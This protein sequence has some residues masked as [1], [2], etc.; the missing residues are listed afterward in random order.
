MTPED[1]L[2]DAL[3]ARARQFDADPGLR[4]GIES[5]ALA[6]QR[7]RRLQIAG[8]SALAVAA[9]VAVVFAL[10]GDSGQEV[11]DNV[12]AD[13]GDTPATTE[14]EAT[15]TTTGEPVAVAP[16]TTTA[17][18]QDGRPSTL[19][20]ADDK[21]LVVLDST[22]GRVLRTL[23]QLPPD[24]GE[25]ECCGHIAS[26]AVTPDGRTAF[27]E[28]AQD[29]GEIWRVPTAG[30]EPARVAVAA[31]RPAIS[32]DGRFL[33]HVSQ[34]GGTAGVVVTDLVS[35]AE[36][37]FPSQSPALPGFL[38]WAPDSQRLALNIA[39][40]L[41][42]VDTATERPLEEAQPIVVPRTSDRPSAVVGAWRGTTGEL[43][44]I[45][46]CCYPEL[47]SSAELV[48]WKDGRVVSTSS[49]GAPLFDIDYDAT[50]AYRLTV[51][52]TGATD[53][54]EGGGTELRWAGA[55]GGG[56]IPGGWT[57]AAW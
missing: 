6:R 27:Y 40:E 55:G 8:A 25:P 35:G 53:E 45:R 43:V 9:A 10:A 47:S 37:R 29:P 42:L 44:V 54:L 39:D 12:R 49:V 7:R 57:R 34:R 1:R 24:N 4:P 51:V 11:G 26:I 50:G 13:Q 17:P 38:E 28:Q 19:V 3:A 14:A 31:S 5:L 16:T 20:A 2:R 21:R 23:V 18:A 36:R 30:G 41:R 15:T 56:T 48:A 46:Y 22:T 33:A 32:P 52:R